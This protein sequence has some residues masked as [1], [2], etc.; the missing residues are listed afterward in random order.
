MR[1]FWL[2]SLGAS[3]ALGGLASAQNQPQ[4]PST[5]PSRAN[6]PANLAAAP[7]KLDPQ[8]VSRGLAAQSQPRR[9]TARGSMLQE[10]FVGPSHRTYSPPELTP[11]D[12]F[13][14]THQQT[15]T[16]DRSLIQPQA[17]DKANKLTPVETS[18]HLALPGSARSLET[19]PLEL[20]TEFKG[21]GAR[22]H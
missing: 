15:L 9:D 10:G 22:D 16:H 1:R 14:L 13:R 18:R 4:F 12:S 2:L 7:N 8:E 3:L 11:P 21:P 5:S 19:P 17:G 6:V 20:M